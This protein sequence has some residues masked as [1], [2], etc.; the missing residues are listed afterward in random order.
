MNALIIRRVR[1]YGKLDLPKV[2]PKVQAGL[3][4]E[5]SWNHRVYQELD[6]KK[7]KRHQQDDKGF[8]GNHIQSQETIHH[9]CKSVS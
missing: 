9:Y 6:W 8:S 5:M 4:K 1:G 3:Q 7:T 2:G